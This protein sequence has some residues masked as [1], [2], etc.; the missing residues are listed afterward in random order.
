M[1]L[2]TWKLNN[3]HIVKQHL[4]FKIC[5]FIDRL[6]IEK[7]SRIMWICCERKLLARFVCLFVC[8]GF[9]CYKY[10]PLKN[11]SLKWR[12]HHYWYK[13]LY[14]DLY[15]ALMAN[16]QWNFFSV[17]LIYCEK[18]HT[19]LMVMSEDPWHSHLLPSV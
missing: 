3:V 18:A 19:F 6:L 5:H 8:Y 7:H 1:Y 11:L 10:I 14:F 17:K 13:T 2:I 9:W 4:P 12:R 15:S 16:E